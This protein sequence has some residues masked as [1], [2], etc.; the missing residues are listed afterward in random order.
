MKKSI[1]N[2]WSTLWHKQTIYGNA[3]IDMSNESMKNKLFQKISI[4]ALRL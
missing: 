1:E 2:F 4:I 3:H